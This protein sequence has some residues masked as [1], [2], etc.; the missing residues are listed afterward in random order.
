[1][2]WW[3]ILVVGLTLLLAA[4]RVVGLRVQTPTVSRRDAG[5]AVRRAA[6]CEAQAPHYQRPCVFEGLVIGLQ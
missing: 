6:S 5:S 2:E 3:V 1:M 4:S